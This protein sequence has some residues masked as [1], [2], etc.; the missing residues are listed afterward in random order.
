LYPVFALGQLVE[1]ELMMDRRRVEDATVA[2]LPVLDVDGEKRLRVEPVQMQW[3]LGGGARLRHQ[4]EDAAGE[5]RRRHGLVEGQVELERLGAGSAER[6]DQQAADQQA[7]AP[8]KSTQH[9]NKLRGRWFRA[10]Q[11]TGCS[12]SGGAVG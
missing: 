7:R 1:R 8:G 10:G 4:D 9:D 6:R 11:G 2:G 5:R 12:V 3:R